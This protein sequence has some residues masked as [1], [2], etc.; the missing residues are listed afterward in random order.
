MAAHFPQDYEKPIDTGEDLLERNGKLYLVRGT[1][2]ASMFKSSKRPTQIKLYK[3]VQAQ[4][5]LFTLEKNSSVP[6]HVLKDIV[7]NPGA[8]MLGQVAAMDQVIQKPDDLFLLKND[9]PQILRAERAGIENLRLARE[10]PFHNQYGMIFPKSRA[11]WVQRFNAK[12]QQVVE[13]GIIDYGFRK[14]VPQRSLAA[15][16]SAPKKEAAQPKAFGMKH[17]GGIFAAEI[18]GLSACFG[19]FLMESRR[20]LNRQNRII[21]Q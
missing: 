1:I 4:D 7:K 8:I 9:F 19:A 18:V 17:F 5:T 2:M 12:L 11:P 6:Y 14:Y 16:N 10:P 13:A 3:Q 21:L 15:L 20:A